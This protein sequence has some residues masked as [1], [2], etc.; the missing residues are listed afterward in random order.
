[1]S[2][3][4]KERTLVMRD[5]TDDII[6]KNGIR[7]DWWLFSAERTSKVDISNVVVELGET[8]PV[9]S[10][11]TDRCIWLEARAGT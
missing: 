10:S 5:Q 4:D 1:M 8:R 9:E 7:V 6:I 11:A 2:M 3:R